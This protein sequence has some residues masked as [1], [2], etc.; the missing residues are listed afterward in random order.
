MKETP[1]TEVNKTLGADLRLVRNPA[2]T[3]QNPFDEYTI[4]EG[5]RQQEQHGG[6]TILLTMSPNTTDTAVR[7]TLAMGVDRAVIVS[8]P[9]LAGSDAI[10]TGRVLAA[11]LQKI[12]YDLALFGQA[13]AD[14]YGGVVPSIVA[15]LLGNP[16]LSFAAKVEV[17]ENAVKIQRQADIGY[18]FAVASLPA[19]VSISKAIN[20]NPRYPSMKGIMTAKKKPVETWSLAD[21][22]VEAGAVGTA[23]ARERVTGAEAVAAQR[24]HEII[25]GNEGAAQR[26]L[27]FLIEQKII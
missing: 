20:N 10:A 2:D 18:T 25:S 14:A 8:D 1:S 16:L 5:I 23:A 11:A 26:I 3:I 6:E 7:R 21:L 19:L 27:A 12:G 15:E 13:S 17:T 24:R 9:A 22:G 4:E